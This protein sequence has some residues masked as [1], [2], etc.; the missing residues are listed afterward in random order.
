MDSWDISTMAESHALETT[1]HHLRNGGHLTLFLDYDGTLVPIAPTPGEAVPDQPLL[2]LLTELSQNPLFQLV[3][4]SGRPL[5]ILKAWLP[6]HHIVLAG[7]YGAEIRINGKKVR[8][9][10]AARQY[11]RELVTVQKNWRQLLN[12]RDGFLLEDKGSA[13]ALHARWADK[14]EAGVVLEAARKTAIGLIDPHQFRLLDGDRFL[15]VAPVTANKGLAVNRFLTDHALPKNLPI[16]FGDDNKDE[17][18]FLIIR[19]WGG[20]SIGVGD[21]YPLL[22]ADEHLASPDDVRDWLKALISVR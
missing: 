21:N 18:A 2:E 17:E 15:E 11:R 16:Y 5:S 20:L 10:I 22:Q 8:Q 6:V 4:I 1:L 7:L 14:E 12:Q 9:G 19:R 13:I 3:I